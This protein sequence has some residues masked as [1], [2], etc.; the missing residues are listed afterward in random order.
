MPSRR[1]ESSR[2]A[3]RPTPPRASARSSTGRLP[4]AGS[5]CGTTEPIPP[6]S[7]S[8]RYASLA[9]MRNCPCVLCLYIYDTVVAV[10]C[11][12]CFVGL[13]SLAPAT[14]IQ[15]TRMLRYNRTPSLP[16]G[17]LDYRLDQRR[18]VDHARGQHQEPAPIAGLLQVSN[19]CQLG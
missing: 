6:R 13:P 3:P 7:S 17:L 5:P 14:S 10:V 9:P 8:S 18:S 15:Y 19:G 2:V 16:P 4:S 11:C 12:C 1:H